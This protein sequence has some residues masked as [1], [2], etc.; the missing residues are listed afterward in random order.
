MK[1]YV[2]KLIFISFEIFTLFI[3][4]GCKSTNNIFDPV[5]YEIEKI[6]EKEEYLET[7]IAYPVFNNLP[8]LNKIV[9]NT[10]VS[11]WKNFKDVQK[12]EWYKIKSLNQRSFFP[13]FVYSVENK[14]SYSGDI[15]SVYIGT[16][17]FT[18][19]AHGNLTLQTYN[20]DKKSQE[21]INIIDA[22]N[23]TYEELSDLCNKSLYKTLISDNKFDLNQ[24]SVDNLNEM[25]EQGTAP[26]AGNFQNF[27]LDGNNV[28]IYFQPY[29]VAPHSYGIQKVQ[30]PLKFKK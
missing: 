4:F 14:V 11:N 8:K 26:F 13:P 19:G 15:V 29:S 3:L 28:I 1:N 22:T 27:M 20:F 17:V 18:G 5:N 25:R 24:E 6:V 21:L 7:D 9:K 12:D 23:Y 16:Y 30:L 10:I 2:K